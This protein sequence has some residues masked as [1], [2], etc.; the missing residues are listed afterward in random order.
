METVNFIFGR[1][2][3]ILSRLIRFVTFSRWSHCGLVAGDWV[4]ESIGNGGFVKTPL[5][6]FKARYNQQWEVCEIPCISKDLCYT[7][8][9]SLL[10]SPYDYQGILAYLFRW[11]IQRINA[12]QCSEAMAYCLGWIREDKLWRISPEYLWLAS[13]TIIKGTGM[14]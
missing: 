4:Y 9:K 12:W 8:A 2:D 10:G 3:K 7:R 11:D 13:K 14:K 5:H 6:V 1:S